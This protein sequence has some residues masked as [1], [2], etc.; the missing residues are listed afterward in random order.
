MKQM[1]EFR[2][3]SNNFLR[4]FKKVGHE[5]YYARWPWNTLMECI[6]EGSMYIVRFSKQ[7]RKEIKRIYNW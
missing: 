5:A 2:I 4:T 1:F 7:E 6:R 3:K